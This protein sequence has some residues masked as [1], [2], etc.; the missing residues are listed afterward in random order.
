[1][2]ASVTNWGHSGVAD[3]LIQRIGAVVMLVW[4]VALAAFF[5]STNGE[6]GHAD[7][8]AL[9]DHPVFK[10]FSL[11]TMLMLCAHS[12]VGLWSISTD[13]LTVRALGPKGTALRL[14]F[15]ALCGLTTFFYLFW[16]VHI[17]WGL[18]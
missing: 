18:G 5:L 1:M 7:W 11:L 9:F 3:W 4:M 16:A 15:Q 6:P 2:V 12:W 10:V 8:R 17:L 13:Y 14:A